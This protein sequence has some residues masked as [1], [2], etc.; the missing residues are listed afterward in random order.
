MFLQ[1]AD[2]HSKWGP[3]VT[4]EQSLDMEQSN[5]SEEFW[6]FYNFSSAAISACVHLFDIR[7]S[8]LAAS[9]SAQW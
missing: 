8:K 7:Q 3:V 2:S 5:L 4:S 1:W 9:W 6:D